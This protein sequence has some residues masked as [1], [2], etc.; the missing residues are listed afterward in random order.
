MNTRAKIVENTPELKNYLDEKYPHVSTSMQIKSLI[1]NKSPYCVVCGGEVK[2]LGKYTCSIKC[3]SAATDQQARVESQ[4]TTLMTKYGV[5]NISKIPGG[6]EKRKTTM[7]ERYGALVSDRTRTA[8][9]QRSSEFNIKGKITVKERYGVSNVSQIPDVKSRKITTCLEKYGVSNISQRHISAN[10][11]EILHDKDKFSA[12]AAGKS[13]ITLS[14]TLGVDL[15]TIYN[16]V[17]QYELPNAREKSSYEFE[18]AEWLTHHCIPYIRNVRAILPS[19]LELDFFFP[20]SN[21]AIEFNGLAHHSEFLGQQLRKN[22]TDFKMYHR[23]KWQECAEQ[24]IQLISIFEDV[25]NERKEV[26]KN[27]ILTLL[28]QNIF[29]TVGARK[30]IVSLVNSRNLIYDFL[31]T[32]HWQGGIRN[33]QIGYG[34]YLGTKLVAVMTFSRRNDAYE[35]TRYCCDN[36]TYPGLFA[37][38]ISRFKKE[39][40]PKKIISF[41]DNTYSTGNIYAVNGFVNV[42][43]VPESYSVTNYK[44]RW[45]RSNF[46]KRILA[47]RYGIDTAGRTELDILRNEFKYDRVWDCGKIKWEWSTPT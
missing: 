14:S 30:L 6:Q 31:N 37:K 36:G 10:S 16:L 1:H 25:W 43:A 21:L 18:I 46:Q 29:P 19:K 9:Y 12:L 44:Q 24:G 3:R 20:N 38:M 2:T 35:L 33:F 15:T 40:L 11:L 47:S 27:R 34:A 28:K 7:I 5:D 23:R 13:I 42:A 41:S 39:Y 4:K 32:Y 17:H 22:S 26:V 45:H 8:A